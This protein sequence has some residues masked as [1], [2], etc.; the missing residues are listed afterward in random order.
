MPL[1][2]PPR[3]VG[4]G[5]CGRGQRGE[6]EVRDQSQTWASVQVFPVTG[7]EESVPDSFQAQ[8]PPAPKAQ[9]SRWVPVPRPLPVPANYNL[10]A[11]RTRPG[12]YHQLRSCPD[13][14]SSFQL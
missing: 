14:N 8:L 5:Q 11:P 6:T 7:T 12:T 9:P 2:C 1:W 13:P 3:P 10:T 4:C